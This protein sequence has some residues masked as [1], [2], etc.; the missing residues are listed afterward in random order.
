MLANAM[1]TAVGDL[2]HVPEVE[3]LRANPDGRLWCVREGTRHDT[4]KSL[5]PAARRQLIQIVAHA[6]GVTVDEANPSFPAELPESGY[7]FHAVVPPQSPDGPTF[8]IRKKPTQVFSLD[9]YVAAQIMTGEQAAYIREVV[10]KRE[11]ILVGGGTGS[12]KTTLTNAILKEIGRIAGRVLTVEDTLELQVEADEVVRQRTVRIG[13]T[14]R[15][16]MQDIVRDMLRLSPDRIIVGEVRGPEAIDLIQGWNTG[17][18]GGVAT[19]H[20][21]SAPDAM[22]RLEDLL[23]QGGYTPVPRQLAKAVNV[24]LFV[25]S[26]TVP[27]PDGLRAKRRLREIVRVTGVHLTEGGHEYRFERPFGS[28]E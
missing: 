14:L 24:I 23:V 28:M 19:I 25:G 9:D 10:G 6:V 27:T 13:D 3:E 16:S 11:N 2:L 1:G 5:S 21:N 20:C 4:G 17:H 15:R 18:P 26:V 7:R 22:E 8:V 12:G